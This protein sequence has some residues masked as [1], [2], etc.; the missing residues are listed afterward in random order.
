MK[1]L[2]ID[3]RTLLKGLGVSIALPA[4][5]AMSPGLLRASTTTAA[6]S[7][8][9]RLAFVYVPNGVNMQTWTPTTLGTNFQL[10]ATLEPLAPFREHLT[11]LSGLTCDKARPNGDGPGD[12]ARAMSAFLT[13]S[14]PRKTDGANIRA[15]ISVDQVVAQRRGNETRFPS[16]EIG[17]EGGRQAGN[18]DSGYSCAYSSNLSWRS[19]STPNP[20]EDNPRAVFDRLFAGPVAGEA[21]QARLRRERYNQSILDFVNED[22]TQLVNRLGVNDRRRMDEY[23]TALR[24]VERR[25]SQGPTPQGPVQPGMARPAGRPQQQDLATHARLMGDL[26]ALA[27]QADLTRVSTFVIANEGSN[28]RYGMINISDG[29]HDLS[30][31]GGNAEKLDKIHR[32]NRFHMEQFAHMLGKLRDVREADGS[33]LLDNCMIVYG[34]GNGDG[35]RHNHDDLPI[36]LLGKGGGTITAGRHLRYPRNLPIANLYVSLL[37][38]MGC[39]VERFGDSTGRLP[40]L[41]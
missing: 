19:E 20:K 29:H 9:R 31:H 38:R 1:N 37:E 15:G 35:N 27:F 6:A 14:Q 41:T 39:P 32:I 16:L 33:S 5:E 8:P 10:P 21:E 40:G 12:H 24:D 11:V 2:P 17:C 25:I 4:L 30:H 22:A 34:S 36:L 3:R 7:P 26:L 18:C 28:R 23:L 13:G